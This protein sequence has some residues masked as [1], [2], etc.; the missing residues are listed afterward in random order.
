MK[1]HCTNWWCFCFYRFIWKQVILD[2]FSW[3]DFHVFCCNLVNIL[4]H[5]L[6]PLLVCWM[7]LFWLGSGKGRGLK[8]TTTLP[9]NV[10]QSLSAQQT[11]QLQS[12]PSEVIPCVTTSARRT[13][14]HTK[15]YTN[16]LKRNSFV[17]E[18]PLKKESWQ[19]IRC[20]SG[21]NGKRFP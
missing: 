11:T 12:S 17:A 5:F 9:G 20:M 14:M 7:S 2:I 3:T 15:L 8:Y 16:T 4:I 21:K 6:P 13:E 10:L 1:S 18:Q 19:T